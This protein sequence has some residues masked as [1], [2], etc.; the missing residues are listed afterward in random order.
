[1]PDQESAVSD[2]ETLALAL[3]RQSGRA[4]EHWKDFE[5]RAAKILE[6]LREFKKKIGQQKLAIGSSEEKVIRADTDDYLDLCIGVSGWRS[7]GDSSFTEDDYR[8][9]G[10]VWRIYKGD[11]DPFPSRP[12][13]HC[14][15]GANRFVGCKLHLGTAQLY[16]GATP[17]GRFLVQK[18]FDQLLTLIR[19]K[20]PD[21]VF[22]LPVCQL[23]EKSRLRK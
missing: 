17:L 20:F 21:L 5:P 16:K 9:A 13:A 8:V 23:D 4:I 18:Q 19:P 10:E 12:H 1:M 14:I 3:C 15:G 2:L 7:S 22:P 11:V 6:E